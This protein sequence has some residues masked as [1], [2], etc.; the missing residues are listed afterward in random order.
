MGVPGTSHS[1]GDGALPPTNLAYFDD[2]RKL[3]SNAIVAGVITVRNNKVFACCGFR[4]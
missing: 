4:L 1:C 2:M 3:H